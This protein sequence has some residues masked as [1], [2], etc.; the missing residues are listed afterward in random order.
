[1]TPSRLTASAGA[2]ALGAAS[3]GLIGPSSA[4]TAKYCHG[5]RA[6]IVVAPHQE[7]V[8]GTDHADVIVGTADRDV[9]RGDAGN[10]VICGGKGKDLIIGSHGRDHLYGGPGSDFLRGASGDDVVAAGRPGARQNFVAEGPG[11]DRDILAAHDVLSYPGYMSGTTDPPVSVDLRSG[12][13]TGQG[14]DRLVMPTGESIDVFVPP[15]STVQGSRYRDRIHGDGSTLYGRGGS[16]HITASGSEV[17]G[18][19]GADLI[20]T[21][22][23]GTHPSIVDGGG[24]DD[25]LRHNVRRGDEATF[26]GGP[27]TDSAHLWLSRALD[28]ST[29]YPTVNLDVAS[30]LSVGPSTW[31]FTGFERV[32]LF[33]GDGVASAI[34]SEG[35][36]GPDWL[37]IH[38]YD[39]APPIPV[40]VHALGGDDQVTTGTG[41]DT[42]DGGDGNDTADTAAGQDTCVSVETRTHCESITP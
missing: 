6:T 42:V 17:H 35:T 9:I 24:G 26:D 8:G 28:Q 21:G 41:D 16:D 40:T 5:H 2:L 29:P 7:Y 22:S 36:D 20:K 34:T 27:G 11:D 1:M 10:D 23:D 31:P 14:Q 37:R 13:A 19:G 12:T 3:L 30:Q 25:R 38:G 33:V 4:A 15:G 39:S 32:S 18:N